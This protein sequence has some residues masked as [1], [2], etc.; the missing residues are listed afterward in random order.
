MKLGCK[1]I[2]SGDGA[3]KG[4][5]V[6]RSAGRKRIVFRRHEI[7]VHEIKPALVSN[8]VPQ[9]MCHA[10][11]DGVP[12]HLGYFQSFAVGA[13]QRSFREANDFACHE[14]QTRAVVFIAA[15]KEH[16]HADADGQNGFGSQSPQDGVLQSRFSK[17][18]HAV[19]HRSLSRKNDT[20]G[21]INFGRALRNQHIGTV[22]HGLDRLT[23]ATQIT[24][25]VIHN[26]YFHS[27]P[28]VLGI[29]SAARASVATAARN[30]R[31][32]ALKIDS[33]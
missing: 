15:L 25:A 24:G 18:A 27:A 23:D 2:V 33:A 13:Y 20:V 30:A 10:L 9:G 32:N 11:R 29:T 26:G 17:T 4:Q 31:A 16:L 1:D 3:D 19:T 6:A 12:P 8:A 22:G 5:T 21:R 28:F 7:A 14:T